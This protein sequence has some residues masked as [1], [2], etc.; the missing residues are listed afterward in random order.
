M[1]NFYCPGCGSQRAIHNV[2][3]GQIFEALRH[4]L[5]VGLLFIVLMYEGALFIVKRVFNKL[6]KNPFHSSLTIKIILAVVII[7]WILRNTT[8]YP[9]SEIAP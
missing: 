7:F 4:N 5:L 2:L 1:T 8:I 3:H 9:F 6:Y